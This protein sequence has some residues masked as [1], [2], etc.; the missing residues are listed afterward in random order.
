MTDN[1]INNISGMA[2]SAEVASLLE[3][4][5]PAAKASANMG[6]SLDDSIAVG[7]EAVEMSISSE[8]ALIELEVGLRSLLMPLYSSSDSNSKHVA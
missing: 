2:S 1:I 8:A 3:M 6:A 7:L 5:M 4:A